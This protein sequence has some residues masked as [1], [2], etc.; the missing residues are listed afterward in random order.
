MNEIKGSLVVEDDG[1]IDL[2][3]LEKGLKKKK[4]KKTKEV[5]LQKTKEDRIFEKS[6]AS[7]V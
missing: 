7:Y 1:E 3:L 5:K 4:S 6:I 2:D